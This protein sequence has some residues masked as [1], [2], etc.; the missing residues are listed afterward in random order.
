LP[1]DGR[2]LVSL[3]P[4]R[5]GRRLRPAATQ[6]SNNVGIVATAAEQLG[7]PV[8]EIDQQ[9]ES[10]TRRVGAAVTEAERTAGLITDL[11]E[12]ASRI[13]TIMAVISS[14]ASQTNLPALDAPIE[15]ARA[16]EAGRD[17]SVVAAEVKELAGQTTRATEEIATQ[18]GRIQSA[19][20]RVVAVIGAV[21][22]RIR[23]IDTTTTAIAAAVEKQPAETQE[24]VRTI[25]Q[26]ASG[27]GEVTHNIGQ[28]ASSARDSGAA[29]AGV[30][31][32]APRLSDRAE[33]L[34]GEVNDFRAGIRAA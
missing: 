2:W 22:G 4:R 14:I 5:G 33:R 19:T 23:A 18:I 21:A 11:D 13:G 7:T 8:S 17:F 16:G 29:A 24:I 30:L 10:S 27:T 9:V 25:G 32:A 3:V 1:A 34:G 31:D 26:A 12:A 15:A 28:I 6:T 20:E